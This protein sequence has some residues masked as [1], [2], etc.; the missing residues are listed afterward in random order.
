MLEN[1][2]LFLLDI[3]GTVCKGNQLIGGTREFLKDIKA[4]GGQYV[5]ITNNATRSVEDYIYF[6]QKLGIPTNHTNFLTASYAT[7]DYLKKHHPN[8]LIYVLGTKSFIQELK[9]NKIR[10][11]TDCEEEEISCVVVSYDNQLT[12]EKL[13]DTCKLLSTKKVDYLATNPDYVCPIEFGFVPDCGA[14]CEMIAHAVKRT[15]YFIGKPE[16]AMVE[17]A[18]QRNRYRKEETV[19]VG[20][21]LYTDILCGYHAGVETVLVLSGEATKEEAEHY[22]Y[23][24]SY[25]MTSVK[26]LHEEW[27]NS[28]V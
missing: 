1:K 26:K 23:K 14:I 25:I 10:V 2:K 20:D 27:K 19:I 16:K 9:K 12:Y 7:M 22:E 13:S 28:I 21:R 4:N 24:P 17:L 5:F 6:F 18:L 8:E 3:D 11:T 15:P